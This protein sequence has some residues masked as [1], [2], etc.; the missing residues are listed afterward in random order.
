MIELNGV[1]YATPW[2][3][4]ILPEMIVYK[5]EVPY[6]ANDVLSPLAKYTL[7]GL[8]LSV[9]SLNYDDN[10]YA[11]RLDAFKKVIDCKK[12]RRAYALLKTLVINELC[13]L[14]MPIDFEFKEGE[15]VK[16]CTGGITLLNRFLI[17]S[18]LKLITVALN[19][20]IN[21]YI[22]TVKNLEEKPLFRDW[23]HEVLINECTDI[24]KIP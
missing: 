24:S 4:R 12:S 15:R 6:K 13:K 14:T 19:E 18:N 10:F 22:L 1:T 20:Y 7:E 11:F 16:T 5:G 3:D 21:Q 23:M 17:I 2:C 8:I 9:I